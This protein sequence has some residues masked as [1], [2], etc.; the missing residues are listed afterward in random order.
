MIPSLPSGVYSL[1]EEVAGFKKFESK[2]NKID[3]NLPATLDAVMQIGNTTDTVEVQATV[4]SIQTETSTLGKLVEGKQLS[5]LQLNGRNPIFLAWLKPGVRGGSL[6]GFSFDLTSGGFN[7]NG[8][9]SQDNLITY[10]GA[11]NND[12]AR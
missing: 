2:N 11:S 8:S 6:A 7:I 10:D 5:D 3:A 1:T 12:P 4:S 9:R